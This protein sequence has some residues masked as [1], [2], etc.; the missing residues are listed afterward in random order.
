MSALLAVP[1][2][3][4]TL[5][6]LGR[7]IIPDTASA[8][9]AVFGIAN[10]AM[11]APDV[12]WITILTALVFLAVLWVGS[13]IFWRRAGVE[14]LGLG[15]A[16]LISAAILCVGALQ[17]WPALLLASLGGIVATLLSRASGAKRD[18]GVPFGPFLAYAIF[19]TFLIS[20]A[21]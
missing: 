14:A 13:E 12:L 9:V 4:L 5:T 15:D 8:A 10:Q 16:K 11:V 17:I 18:S 20:G 19:L 3:W 1:L 6:D 2:V 21:T 7:H